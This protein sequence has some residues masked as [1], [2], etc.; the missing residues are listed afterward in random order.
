MDEGGIIPEETAPVLGVYWDAVSVLAEKWSGE[1][2]KAGDAPGLTPSELHYRRT[3]A[4]LEAFLQTSTLG[5]YRAR[6][7]LLTS[8]TC[9]VQVRI[10]ALATAS[11]DTDAEAP[12]PLAEG[13][14]AVQRRVAAALHNTV[15]YYSQ[16][17]PNVEIALQGGLAPIEKDLQDFVAL[18]KWEDRGYYAMRASTEKAHRHL[19]K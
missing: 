12:S 10:Q 5:E 16:F 8:F 9:H 17:V 2:A 11:A 1:D 15:R 19:H 14:L 4:T 18:A 13:G 3:A 7:A 6:L